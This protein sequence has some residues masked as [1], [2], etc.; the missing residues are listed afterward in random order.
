MS[1]RTKSSSDATP[2]CLIFPCHLHSAHQ[3]FY[4][5]C[6]LT[7]FFLFPTLSCLQQLAYSVPQMKKGRLSGTVA[8]PAAPRNK[9]GGLL[10]TWSGIKPCSICPCRFTCLI[11]I[12]NV[13]DVTKKKLGV[14]PVHE[15]LDQ[16]CGFHFP[17]G[18]W[19]SFLRCLFHPHAS[20]G[21]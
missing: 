4:E 15:S 8:A 6:A 19:L 17:L 21:K 14:I 16:S 7:L 9:S 20:S 1:F 11:N 2:S 10:P 5:F 18:G 13:N 12:G 3:I